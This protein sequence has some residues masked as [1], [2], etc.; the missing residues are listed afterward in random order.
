M[1]LL[2]RHHGGWIPQPPDARDFEFLP[3]VAVH[4]K[5]VA[6]FLEISAIP[7][8]QQGQ[9][10]SC[11]GNATAGIVM[12]DQQAQGEPIVLPSRS[13]IYWNARQAEGTTAYDSGAAVRDAV[14]GVAKYGV[15]PD[16]E[17]PY[18]DR[19]FNVA[20]SAQDYTDAV[21]QEAL[22]YESVRYG[23]LDQAI[24]SGFPFVFG[25]S[26]YESFESPE[27]ASTGIVPIP[28]PGERVLG[29]H[30]VWCYGY[31]SSYTKNADWLPPR[32]KACR[33]SW[34]DTWGNGG[35]F[36]LPQW[37]FD[38]G[39]ATDYWVIRR[40]GPAPAPA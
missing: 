35:D 27:V 10:G 31:N 11:T 26:V 3:A 6:Q 4:Q 32:T 16:S 2:K 18:D 28:E 33:N 22:V 12:Y 15:C 20:P 23:H 24:A 21:R 14:G 8:L 38:K 5:P 37:F 25:F 36:V 9:Q 7:V 1:T 13:F 29:G 40:I 30:C 19:V 39:Q 34:G 17:F